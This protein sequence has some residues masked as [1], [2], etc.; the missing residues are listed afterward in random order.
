MKLTKK[1]LLVIGG[2]SLG[3]GVSEAVFWYQ[4]DGAFPHVNFYVQDDALGARLQ[5]NATQR[6]A[7]GGNPT[8]R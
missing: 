6:I 7:F 4:D 5:P 3:L 1:R 8:T 2:L